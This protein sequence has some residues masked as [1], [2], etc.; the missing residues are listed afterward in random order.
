MKQDDT[1]ISAYFTELDG[2]KGDLH[3]RC[4][5]YARWTVPSAF[6]REDAARGST[7]QESEKGNVAI[8][9]R[10]VNHLGHRIVD[11]MFPNDKPFFA[12]GLTKQAEKKIMKEADDQGGDA[13]ETIQQLRAGLMAAE[14][15]AMQDFNLTGYRPVAVNAVIQKII[16]GNACIRRMDDD[17]RVVYSV[18][19]YVVNRTITGE[20]LECVLRDTKKFGELPEDIQEDV[21]THPKG[22]NFKPQDDVLLYT[23]VWWEDKR[24]HQMQAV[25]D[26]DIE[27]GLVHFKKAESPLIVMAWNLGRGDHY[28]R[29]LVEDYAVSFHNIDV[30]TSAMID[31]IGMA[32]DIKFLVNP[33]A[34]LDIDAYNQARRGEYVSGA[35]DDI[36]VP[37]FEF[38][39][40]INV[41]ADTIAK[42]ERELAQAFLLQSAGVR[43]AE[44]V[45]AEEIRFFA[46]EIESAFGG[47]Y[48]RLALD[49]QKKE[50]EYQLSKIDFSEYLGEGK[51]KTFQ[52]VVTTGLE[53]LSREGK[54]DNLRLAVMDLGMLEAV[55]EEIRAAIH[56]LK[57][58]SFIFSNRSVGAEEFLYTPDE[59]QQ[60]QQAKQ[61]QEAQL[62][63]QQGEQQAAV[64]AMK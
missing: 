33:T 7:P 46:R 14:N 2:K 18:R 4:E 38:A 9:A 58:A 44:R 39:T 47:L 55:P 48:S 35:K 49:W 59:F 51:E 25:E 10:L 56:P 57:F 12:I 13:T 1:S 6:P 54:L 17:S 50:A 30:M 40:Q 27:D 36:T 43:D 22:K 8:G 29:G 61:Q 53:S 20:V 34:G 45:T 60:N 64:Q 26:V 52:I 63:A 16:T 42:L 41:I 32:A 37:Q 23:Y 19:D 5:Q 15:E 3:L 62:A 21:A 11:T 31:M 28:G 24:W